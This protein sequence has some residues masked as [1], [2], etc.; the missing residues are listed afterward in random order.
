MHAEQ[1]GMSCGCVRVSVNLS[2]ESVVLEDKRLRNDRATSMLTI[3]VHYVG[4][5]QLVDKFLLSTAQ[6]RIKHDF[7]L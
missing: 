3:V 2:F 5:R 7:C 4:S 1:D 6:A